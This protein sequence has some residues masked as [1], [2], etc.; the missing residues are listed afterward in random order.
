MMMLAAAA[1]AAD[2]ASLCRTCNVGKPVV[3]KKLIGGCHLSIYLL[4]CL[5]TD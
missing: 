2:A 3:L 1:G 5:V 4:Y